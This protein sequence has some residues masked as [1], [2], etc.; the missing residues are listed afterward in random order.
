MAI[1]YP[2]TPPTSPGYRSRELQPFTRVGMNVSPFT[3][4]QQVYAW[5]AQWLQFAFTLPVMGDAAAGNWTAFFMALNGMEGTFYLGDSVRKTPRGNIAGT[6][7]VG[8]G[9]VANAT[10][11]PLSGGTGAF[12]VGD[13]LQ[14]FATTSA[15]LHRVVQ[16]NAGSVD[17][18]PRLRS[19]Y[20]NGSAI[21]YVNPV[22]RFRLLSIPAEAFDESKLCQG[23]SFTAMEVL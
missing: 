14:V 7:T 13:W 23:I 22:G 21:T 18:F 11:L 16:V 19:A 2:L 20:A 3:G 10:T 4:A 8:S 5:Q 6:V 12:A 17:V 9:A 1:S 15:R